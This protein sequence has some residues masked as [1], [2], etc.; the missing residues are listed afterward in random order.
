MAFVFCVGLVQIPHLPDGC[1]PFAF[2]L[3][4]A[5]LLIKKSWWE[6]SQ[7]RVVILPSYVFIKNSGVMVR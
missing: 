2:T 1:S 7:I 5:H 6:Y 3:M 4:H